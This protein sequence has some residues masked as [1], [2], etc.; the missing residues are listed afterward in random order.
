[1]VYT[2]VHIKSFL[3]FGCQTIMLCQAWSF[4]VNGLDR[5]AQITNY[6]ILCCYIFAG[7]GFTDEPVYFSF[8]V[9]TVWLVTCLLITCVGLQIRKF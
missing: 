4:M 8:I 5:T 3:A 6:N 9:L 1:M 2:E 7:W